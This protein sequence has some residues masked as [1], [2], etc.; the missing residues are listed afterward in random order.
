MILCNKISRASSP[1]TGPT[2]S[3]CP[4]PQSP[5]QLPVP[6][7][8]QT[9][10]PGW[11][12]S[13]SLWRR[14]RIPRLVLRNLLSQDSSRALLTPSADTEVLLHHWGGCQ[15]AGAACEQLGGQQGLL[16]APDQGW[17]HQEEDCHFKKSSLNKWKIILWFTMISY[18]S[19]QINLISKM[20]VEVSCC[21]S[22]LS[23]FFGRAF[24]TKCSKKSYLYRGEVKKF[25]KITKVTNRQCIPCFHTGFIFW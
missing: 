1:A 9:P 7:L 21:L 20:F 24:Q 14:K 8:T 10:R 5:L 19:F 6:K 12:K 4:S 13:S 18:Y 25:G 22:R 11:Q 16:P 2:A 3:L 17:G 15:L 23:G